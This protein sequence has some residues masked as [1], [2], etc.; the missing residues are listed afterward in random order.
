MVDRTDTTVRVGEAYVSGALTSLEDGARTRL[1]YELLAEVVES[2]G[3][4]AYLPHRVTDPVTASHLDPRA[5]YRLVGHGARA[6]VERALGEERR[7][8]HDEGVRVLLEYYAA[9]CLDHTAPYPGLVELVDGVERPAS[10]QA[11]SDEG[12]LERA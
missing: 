11:E 12:K 3:L 5:V 1:F 2:A 6:L 8:L 10:R 9:H 4:R 7:E